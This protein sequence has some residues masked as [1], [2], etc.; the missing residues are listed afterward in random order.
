MQL[1]ILNPMSLEIELTK[2]VK[3]NLSIQPQVIPK[4][5]KFYFEYLIRKRESTVTNTNSDSFMLCC[6]RFF[7]HLRYLKEIWQTHRK[8]SF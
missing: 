1:H 4:Y 8:M 5:K 3:N 6:D 2:K 7:L